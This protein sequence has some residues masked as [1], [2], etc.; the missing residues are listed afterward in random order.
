MPAKYIPPAAVSTKHEAKCQ[1]IG[2]RNNSSEE[3]CRISVSLVFTHPELLLSVLRLVATII[4]LSVVLTGLL[5][6]LIIVVRLFST[7]TESVCD[8]N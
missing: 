1:A 8:C 4:G 5:S 2:I 3:Y 6:K 7:T